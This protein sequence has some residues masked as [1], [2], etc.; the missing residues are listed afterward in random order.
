MKLS[1]SPSVLSPICGM[2]VVNFIKHFQLLIVGLQCIHKGSLRYKDM[3]FW[4]L[5]LL[6]YLSVLF[7]KDISSYELTSLV[8]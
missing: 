6:G 2:I 8:N 4:D 1:Y 7:V 5:T 3:G